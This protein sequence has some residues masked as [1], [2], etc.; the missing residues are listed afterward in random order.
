MICTRRLFLSLSHRGCNWFAGDR[1]DLF[2]ENNRIG[3]EAE[4]ETKIETKAGTCLLQA[5]RPRDLYRGS[6]LVSTSQ[7]QDLFRTAGRC[8]ALSRLLLVL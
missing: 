5:T 6:L 7:F 4:T 3:P 2:A 1:M 8:L